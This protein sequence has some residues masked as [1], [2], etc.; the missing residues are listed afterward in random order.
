MQDSP[1]QTN[2]AVPTPK[3]NRYRQHTFL[4]KGPGRREVRDFMRDTAIFLAVPQGSQP[5]NADQ[6]N[7]FFA[8]ERERRK[9][10]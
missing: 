10:A 3:K 2:A 9:N 8:D 4:E 1:E 5:L 6:I 7:K